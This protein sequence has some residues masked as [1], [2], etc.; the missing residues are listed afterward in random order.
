MLDKLKRLFIIED[1]NAQTPKV[2]ESV[3]TPMSNQSTSSTQ[4]PTFIPN[5]T[6]EGTPDSK[7]IDILLGALDKNNLEGYDYLE[8]KQALQSLSK[9][10]M[11]EVTKYKSA[12]AMAGTMGADKAQILKTA[13]HYLGILQQEETKFSQALN[14]NKQ[15]LA[16]SESNG[17]TNLEQSIANKQKQ[18]ENLLAEIEKD[19]VKLNELKGSIEESSLKISQT[20]ANFHAAY[21]LVT[22]QINEDL[23]K[24][25]EYVN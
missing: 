1:P 9:V 4:K 21:Q 16:Q 2:E 5:P 14:A 25:K 20:A 13:D 17:L 11:D 18:V 7:F 24:I 6:V 3:D 23:K 10:G 15:K 22:G 8:Y 19:K 12:L